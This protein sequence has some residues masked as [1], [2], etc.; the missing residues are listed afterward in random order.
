[1]VVQ[2]LLRLTKCSTDTHAFTLSTEYYDNRPFRRLYIEPKLRRPS[3]IS[4]TSPLSD[5]SLIK[6]TC[7]PPHRMGLVSHSTSIPRSRVTHQSPQTIF[8][9]CFNGL[10]QPV[11][12]YRHDCNG[13]MESPV[14]CFTGP[15][16]AFS[17]GITGTCDIAD[18][19]F[20][21]PLR[22]VTGWTLRRFVLCWFLLLIS[23]ETW[24][25]LS[26]IP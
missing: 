1:M 25:Y 8:Y 6:H 3:A 22:H 7:Q 20:S 13:M 10:K 24:P 9:T 23:L 5:V 2:T 12:R 15:R 21:T 4:I 11:H 18:K 19:R 14:G 26:T 16:P 17:L